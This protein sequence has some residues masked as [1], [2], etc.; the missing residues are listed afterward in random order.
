[1]SLNAAAATQE[2][3]ST[4]RIYKERDRL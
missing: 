1:M 2:G 4:N 3:D